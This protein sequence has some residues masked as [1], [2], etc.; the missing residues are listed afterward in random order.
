MKRSILYFIII[1]NSIAACQ[2]YESLDVRSKEFL[3]TLQHRTFLYF[4]NE[5]NPENGLVRDRSAEWSPA[6]IA[7]T[8]FGVA[9]WVIGAENK[10][11]SRDS[12][13]HLV[14]TLVKFL[15]NSDQRGDTNSTGFNGFYYHFLKMQEGTREWNSEL[16][17]I[18]T[19]LLLAGLRV[20]YNYFC[21]DNK[22]ESEIRDGIDALSNRIKWDWM[23]IRE[24]N[25]KRYLNALSMGWDPLSGYHTHGWVGYNEG[26]IM[27][28][29]AAGSGFEGAKTAYRVWLDDYDWFESYPGLG[30]AAYPPLFV[31]QYPQMFIDFRNIYDNFNRTSGI[32]YFENSRRATLSQR[33]YAIDNPLG[34]KGYDSL[35]W[36]WT[37]CDGPGSQYS[38]PQ[39]EVWGYAGRGI[40]GPKLIFFDDG[41]IAPTASASSIA[42]APEVVIP[43]LLNLYNKYGEKGLWGKYGFLDSFNPTFN[44]FNKDYIGIDQGPIVIMIQN[45]KNGFIWDLMKK[46]QIVKKGLEILDFK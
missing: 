26:L 28:I 23:V 1:L 42:F 16:S 4:I 24:Y 32:D 2:S 21:Y 35:T 39:R 5:I 46:D 17:S 25:D 29:V 38:T 41:T 44:W 33:L 14:N 11:I 45:Y 15:L 18:D 34:Y 30:H 27:Y 6:S 20:A 3:D 10:W 40:S 8:G 13:A 22:V 31:H 7:S 37:A 43:T 19:G 36:G 9:C 12:A